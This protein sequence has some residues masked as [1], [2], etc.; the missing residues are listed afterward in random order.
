MA[1]SEHRT[2]IDHTEL[3]GWTGAA[4]STYQDGI[5]F[6][7]CNPPQTSARIRVLRNYIHD[8]ARQGAG[9]GVVSG[10]GGNAYVGGNTFAKNRHAVSATHHGQTRYTAEDNLVLDSSNRYCSV[11]PFCWKEQDL[12]VH[13]SEDPGH[14]E[15][16]RAGFEFSMGFNTFYAT[17]KNIHIRGT[18]CSIARIYNNV[19]RESRDTAIESNSEVSGRVQ[20]ADSNAFQASTD[21]IVIGDFDGDGA[22]DEFMATGAAWYYR[23][24]RTK[25]WR[26]LRR[27]SERSNVLSFGDFDG[28]RRTDVRMAYPGGSSDTSWGA[29]S[30][31]DRFTPIV[32]IPISL[33]GGAKP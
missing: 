8:N 21:A 5:E 11:W 28:D 24:G 33:S 25:E 4:V 17:G 1:V 9:Y 15:G 16:G 3:S 22:L 6:D 18:P 7:F 31:W 14:W 20:R 32:W 13:G 10:V 30:P 27:A 19:F 23:A 2:L 29:S 26:F 12:D